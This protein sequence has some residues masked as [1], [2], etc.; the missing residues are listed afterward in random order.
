MGRSRNHTVHKLERC[1]GLQ[2]WKNSVGLK[3]LQGDIEVLKSKHRNTAGADIR[4][5]VQLKQDC[6]SLLSHFG[7]YIWPD[8][9]SRH[10]ADWLA[11]A[12]EDSTGLYPIDLY[13]SHEEHAAKIHQ[14]FQQLV[15]EKCIIFAANQRSKSR[16]ERKDQSEIDYQSSID[17]D[18]EDLRSE[19]RSEAQASTTDPSYSVVNKGMAP[20]Q[21][22]SN[23]QG[24]LPPRPPPNGSSHSLRDS[25]ASRGS[26]SNSATPSNI[27]S[28]REGSQ[29]S[30][31]FSR[32]GTSLGSPMKQP[33]KKRAREAL[34]DE[35]ANDQKRHHMQPPSPHPMMA[36][37]PPA[38]MGAPRPTSAHNS[39]E[40]S[41]HADP[42]LRQNSGALSVFTELAHVAS[43]TALK[44]LSAHVTFVRGGQE[45]LAQGL[46]R[47]NDYENVAAFF[48][49]L[50]GKVS[51]L[52]DQ[53]D[54]SVTR[55]SI[56]GIAGMEGMSF[57]SD[58]GEEEW[59][60]F[61]FCLQSVKSSGMPKL[62]GIQV[63]AN[64]SL[65]GPGKIDG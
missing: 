35:R 18:E 30:A 10:R 43:D 6:T 37:P 48:K 17:L 53:Q 62:A 8:Y 56:V 20:V 29:E 11:S 42:R 40:S 1:L 46:I 16:R 61:Q 3:K 12:K 33:D 34:G 25:H 58:F 49:R 13:W 28:Q 39:P 24:S 47:V 59:E 44:K 36:P 64:V 38:V 52:L 57:N 45:E 32:D 14:H 41:T 9:P 19:G 50:E 21:S 26:G 31:T 23:G 27:Y 51:S 65:R 2:T 63:V 22:R 5:S 7:S 60:L 15:V 54:V 4:R 55:A